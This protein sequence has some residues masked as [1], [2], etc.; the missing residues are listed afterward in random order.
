M[1]DVFIFDIK[2]FK[3][4]DIGKDCYIFVSDDIKERKRVRTMFL[5][6]GRIPQFVS[7]FKDFGKDI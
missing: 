1:K 3:K 7:E 6:Q 2:N 4:S 5:E